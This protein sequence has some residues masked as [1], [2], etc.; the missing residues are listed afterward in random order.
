MILFGL[1]ILA[2]EFKA[3]D[4]VLRNFGFLGHTLGRGG[5]YIWLSLYMLGGGLTWISTVITM[6]TGILYLFIHFKV[7]V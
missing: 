3:P 4:M 7:T 1:C 5:F 6:A 2:L